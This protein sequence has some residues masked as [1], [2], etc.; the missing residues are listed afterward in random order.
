MKRRV[1]GALAGAALIAALTAVG[2]GRPAGAAGTFILPSQVPLPEGDL[3]EA[4]ILLE[5]EMKPASGS[6]AGCS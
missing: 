1:I 6:R 2:V 3:S 4:C 5:P